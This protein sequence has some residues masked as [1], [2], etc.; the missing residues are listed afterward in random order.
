[1]TGEVVILEKKVLD[2]RAFSW[3]QVSLAFSVMD[4]RSDSMKSLH[5]ML[6]LD[7]LSPNG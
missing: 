7:I 5:L 4:I 3:L 2:S 1:M 6:I